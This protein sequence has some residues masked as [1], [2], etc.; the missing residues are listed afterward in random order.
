MRYLTI[1]GF[2]LALW[3][4]HG[5]HADAYACNS[6]HYVNSS[7]VVVHSPSCGRA[8]EGHETAVCR[9]GANSDSIRPL[10]PI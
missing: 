1:L 5:Q 10:I 9:D 2:A 3:S 6:R 4:A 7:G 8:S